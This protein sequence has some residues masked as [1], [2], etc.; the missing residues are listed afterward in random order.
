MYTID[1]SVWV[2]GFDS[3]ED[4]YDISRRLLRLLSDRR[5]PV[6]VPSLV[7]AEVAGAV[8]RTRAVP[9][10]AMAFAATI[11][12]LPHVKL[13]SLDDAMA[14][15]AA[16]LAAQHALRGADA[17]YAAA[18]LHGGCALVT[19]DDE[20]LRRLKG[21]VNAITPAVALA[22]LAPTQAQP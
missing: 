13:L 14:H 3:R 11:A 20:Q 21:V 22:T 8:T 5:I 18:A 17:V 7:L 19:L 1:A 16:A 9:T 15:E 6:V 12:T 10:Q 4:G 2:N